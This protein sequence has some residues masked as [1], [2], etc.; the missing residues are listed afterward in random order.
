MRATLPSTMPLR[1]S[2]CGELADED[3]LRLGLGDADLGLEPE[4]VG[5]AG[6]IGARLHLRADFDREAAARARRS[7]RRGP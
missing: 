5:H 4:R 6:E 3:V 7:C 1:V 2:I